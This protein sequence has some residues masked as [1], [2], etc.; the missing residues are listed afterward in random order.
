MRSRYI[1]ALYLLSVFCVLLT[2]VLANNPPLLSNVRAQQRSD[3]KPVDIPY[4]V[5]IGSGNNPP[6]VSNVRAQQRSGTK[7]V[8]IAYDVSDPDSDLLTI[9]VAVSDDGGATF[10]VPVFTL[11]GDVDEGIAPGTNKNIVWNAGIDF[12]NVYRTNCRVKITARDGGGNGGNGEQDTDC[13]SLDGAPMVMIP[14]GQ[15]QMGD[16]FSEGSGDERPA[17]LVHVDTF[18]IDVNEVDNTQYARFLNDYGGTVGP[19]GHKLIDIDHTQCLIEKVGSEYQP[20]A[21]Y[22]DYPAVMISW[23]GAY[24]YARFYSKRLPTEAEFEKAARGGLMGNR[25]PWGNSI[26]PSDANYRDNT[27]ADS[28]S[29]TYPVGSFAPNGYGLFD[30]G[31]NVQEWCGDWYESNSY[32]KS[33]HENPHGPDEG[34]VR[35]RRG[36]GYGSTESDMRVADRNYLN[37]EWERADMGFRCVI[38]INP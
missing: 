29:N 13:P 32:G 6:L 21:G 3:T 22:G 14:G 20:K 24:E 30:M 10:N 8:D 1:T 31:G 4:D 36:G 33:S 18:C 11:S 27:D 28:L 5:T 16:S 23:F 25:Y 17:H 19:D 2:F 34:F 26:S 12:P 35:V 9:S 7:L 37:P 15:F 38:D